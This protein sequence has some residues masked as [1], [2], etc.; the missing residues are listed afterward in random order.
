MEIIFPYFS[1]LSAKFEEVRLKF[2]K[3]TGCFC[4]ANDDLGVASNI[5]GNLACF[6]PLN[7]KPREINTSEI[8]QV[9]WTQM[10]RSLPAPRD[11]AVWKGDSLDCMTFLAFASANVP[12]C[13]LEAQIAAKKP[14]RHFRF[15][16][17]R[18]VC[19][20]SLIDLPI[21]LEPPNRDETRVYYCLCD[22]FR[23]PV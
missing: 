6:A 23:L 7:G 14:V 12:N 18:L 16:S 8:Q 4:S 22:K 19:V 21:A 2:F 20:S 15:G 9:T 17:D 1:V 5:R 11:M 13:E 3:E 10:D